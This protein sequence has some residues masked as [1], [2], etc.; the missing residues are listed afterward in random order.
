M[1]VLFISQADILEV[2]DFASEGFVV[3]FGRTKKLVLAR[4]HVEGMMDVLLQA[5]SPISH[6]QTE[7]VVSNIY[8]S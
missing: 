6:C 8:P 2:S 7:E 1:E 5:G 3:F 4:E